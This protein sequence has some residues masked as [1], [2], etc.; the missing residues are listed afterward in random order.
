LLGDDGKAHPWAISQ[1]PG[2]TLLYQHPAFDTGD[3][4]PVIEE[5]QTAIMPFGKYRGAPLDAVVDDVAYVDSHGVLNH[6]LPGERPKVCGAIGIQD[7]PTRRNGDDG[8]PGNTVGYALQ[9]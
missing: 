5:R 3:R 2:G 9:C 7:Q 1:L 8:G 4:K 6:E